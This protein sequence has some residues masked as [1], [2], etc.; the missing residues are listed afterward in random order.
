MMMVDIY[1]VF[2]CANTIATLE[3]LHH[4]AN[5][6]DEQTEAQNGHTH[7]KHWSRNSNRGS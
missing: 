5:I 4:Y 6:T 2:L 7:S 3:P 1:L